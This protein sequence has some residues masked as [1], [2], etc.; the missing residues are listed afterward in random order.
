MI[1]FVKILELFLII[2]RLSF[3]AERLIYKSEIGVDC[4]PP[5]APSAGDPF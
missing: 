1:L 2:S 3:I 5:V 4:P